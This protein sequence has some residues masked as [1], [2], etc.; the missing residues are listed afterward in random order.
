MTSRPLRRARLRE[1]VRDGEVVLSRGFARNP[2][3]AE[4]LAAGVAL[5]QRLRA[6]AAPRRAL[7]LATAAFALF[8]TSAKTNTG[9]GNI[10]V[11]C[12]K[13]CTYCCHLAVN[14]TVPEILL[15]AHAAATKRYFQD[16]PDRL[17]RARSGSHVPPGERPGKKLPCAILSDG[18]CSV[19]AQRPTMCRVATSFDVADCIDEFEG[20]DLN[21]DMRVARLPLDM[22][23]NVRTALLLALDLQGLDGAL[24][25]LAGGLVEAQDPSVAARWLAGEK[26]FLA[27][28]DLPPDTAVAQLVG[29]L[30]AEARR[31]FW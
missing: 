9:A 6:G 20:R 11:A 16:A 18:A 22:G 5:N 15:V 8:E 17:E 3:K 30:A 1:W 2:S 10:E 26:A 23:F 29:E 28:R 21:A 19:Y 27:T 12:R 31:S 14:A 13:G 4:I 24:Y 25:D 7:D